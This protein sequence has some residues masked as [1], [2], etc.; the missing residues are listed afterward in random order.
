GAEFQARQIL[1][2][3]AGSDVFRLA[4]ALAAEATF[5]AAQGQRGA[6]RTDTAVR[7]CTAMA[8]R[9]GQ[10]AALGWATGAA[11][12]SAFQRGQ[13]KRACEQL[14]RAEEILREQ[15]SG[16]AWERAT[17][18]SHLLFT[19]GYLGRFGDAATLGRQW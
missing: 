2:A 3:N 19:L 10:P 13:W 6:R 16:M 17:V 15:C 1:Y 18:Q 4:R 5:S 12:F 9:S 7:A 11:G 14:M 8:E